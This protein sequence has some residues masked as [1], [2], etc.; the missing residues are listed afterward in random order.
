MTYP[1][2]LN[3]KVAVNKLSFPL[4]TQMVY[5]HARFDSYGLLQSGY[6]DEHF[7]ERLYIQ[8]NDKVLSIRRVNLAGSQHI[9]CRKLAYLSNAYSYAHF[10]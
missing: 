7:L 3:T 8:V 1:E 10:Q 6:G 9:F 2:T 4:I 5:F